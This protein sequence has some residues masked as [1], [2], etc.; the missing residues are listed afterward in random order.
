MLCA[1]AH[2]WFWVSVSALNLRHSE[3]SLHV[4]P[5]CSLVLQTR[6]PEEVPQAQRVPQLA[7]RGEPVHITGRVL[8]LTLHSSHLICASPR[9][10]ALKPRLSL[11]VSLHRPEI[12]TSHSFFFTFSLWKN[13]AC[14]CQSVAWVIFLADWT[15]RGGV[16]LTSL[17]CLSA[18]SPFVL[19]DSFYVLCCTARS[20]SDVCDKKRH[21]VS[22]GQAPHSDGEWSRHIW[23]FSTNHTSTLMLFFY[24]P[25]RLLYT[26]QLH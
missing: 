9:A 16:L 8:Q 5:F 13:I 3:F 25:V 21:E 11:T 24:V 15:G 14:T 1:I 12:E 23:L 7:V 10:A 4:D 20:L 22:P 2:H 17:P 6:P 18:R 26:G 19:T